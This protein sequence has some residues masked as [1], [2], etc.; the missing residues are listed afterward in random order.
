[1]PQQRLLHYSPR[2]VLHWLRLTA[3]ASGYAGSLLFRYASLPSVILLSQGLLTGLATPL[4]V[5]SIAGL[6]T[7]LA[8]T[9]AG[10]QSN[11]W[12]AVIP[13]LAVL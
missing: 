10:G 4:V 11:P 7:V 5:W 8:A 9:Q 2:R 6:V 13:W 1:M 3:D 12:S